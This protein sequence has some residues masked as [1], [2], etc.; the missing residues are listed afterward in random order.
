MARS[1]DTIQAPGEPACTS[2][3]PLLAPSSVWP[4]SSKGPDKAPITV[5][6]FCEFEAFPC[7]R[8]N[9]ILANLFD[10]Q[11]QVRLI[12]KHAPA[13][14][15][16][17]SLLAHEAALAA[18]AQGRF[19][20]M[21]DLLYENQTRL[22]RTDLIGYA[23][24]IGLDLTSFQQAL[25]NHTYR[26][27]VERDLAEAKGLGATTTPTL[28]INGRRLT[29]PQSYASLGAVIDSL[30]AGVPKNML[31]SEEILS[32]GPAVAI[33]LNGAPTKGPAT[34]PISIVEFSDFEC[35]FCAQSASAIREVLTAYPT[36]VRF[37][38]KHY[39]L[40]F[41]RESALAHEAAMAAQAQGKF[42]EMH[43]LLFAEQHKLTREDLIEKAR[44]LKFDVPRFISDLDGHR[45]KPQ[46]D[47]DRQEGDRLGVDGTPFFFVN[48]HTFSGATTFEEFKRVIDEELKNAAKP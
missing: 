6:A 16:P 25:D 12:F 45:F 17:N 19:W 21:H 24:R 13:S 20:E 42:W 7:S 32:S 44:Q 15:N 43:D 11:K 46:V 38:F 9:N 18:G 14:T 23:K 4:S 8:L 10:Q 48:G 41:H 5:M 34:A 39:P 28:F 1:Q 22:S 31:S 3:A 27:I 40:P 35:P 30:L 36:E 37:S 26:L 33:N 29:G 47:A 2:T